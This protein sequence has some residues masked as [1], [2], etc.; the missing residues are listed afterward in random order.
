MPI[1]KG[2]VRFG[3]QYRLPLGRWD[4][5]TCNEKNKINKLFKI[6]KIRGC[7]YVD[8]NKKLDLFL[9]RNFLPMF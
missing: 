1:P 3:E 5:D 9:Q 6:E 8:E 7:R 2:E 4:Q